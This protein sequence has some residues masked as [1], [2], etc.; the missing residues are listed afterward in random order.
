M[1]LSLNCLRGMTALYVSN[2]FLSSSFKGWYNA[3]YGIC[4]VG[5]G[6]QS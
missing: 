6:K 2:D 3:V 1:L 4:L 5:A